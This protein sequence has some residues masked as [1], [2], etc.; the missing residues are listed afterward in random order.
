MESIKFYKLISP[1]AE[2]ITMDC[3]LSMS[4]IDDN[5]LAFKDNDIS[6]ATFDC[7]DFFIDIIRNN[8]ESINIDLSCVRD[9][10][11]QEIDEA[12]SGITPQIIEINL[13]GEVSEDGVLTLNW[14][15]MSGEQST[16]IS[17]FITEVRRDSTLKGDGTK[18]D[19]LGIANVEQT[20]YYKP[21]IDFVDELPEP[22]TLDGL[23]E[24]I[25][26]YTSTTVIA[27]ND[28]DIV[29]QGAPYTGGE[30]SAVRDGVLNF[31]A[32]RAYAQE[33]STHI[34]VYGT[35]S[36]EGNSYLKFTIN[37]DYLI[38]KIEIE[39]TGE[40]YIKTWRDQNGNPLIIFDKT[41]TWIGNEQ[42]VTLTNQES[43][44]AR[45]KTIKVTYI[46]EV[47]P[48][49]ETNS[50]ERWLTKN[51]FSTFGCLYTRNGLDV[52]KSELEKNGSVWRIPTKED[53]D[54]LL[55]FVDDCDVA[56]SGETIGEYQ[57]EVCGKMLKSKNYWIGN[58]NI[59]LIGFSALPSGYVLNSILTGKDEEC[60]FWTDT[61]HENDHKYIK[62]F[63]YNS[64]AAL[65]DT[66]EEGG[67]YSIRLVRDISD[68]Y[69]SDSVN[70]LGNT[71]KVINIPDIGQSWIKY[72]LNF[73]SGNENC[74]KFDYEYEG[75]LMDR[76]LINHWNGQNWDK[77]ELN[78][79]DKINTTSGRTVTEYTCVEDEHGN[80]HLVKGI[81]YEINNGIKSMIIDAGWY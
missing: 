57:G 14:T 75:T 78:I 32:N 58:T 62:G 71:Y 28:S 79:G 43:G 16:S 77:K 76:Y 22:G 66:E 11:Q 65:Q 68:N 49:S 53:W 34:K 61:E 35:N 56:I 27:Y 21:V 3:K 70:I 51:T 39:A 37:D 42:I 1:Y 13:S 54:A 6:A 23:G 36:S 29:G 69:V 73:N 18:I 12:I 59:D 24:N 60:R 7:E 52:V 26:V 80:Q 48:S 38:T 50:G 64:D 17:G 46:K 15:D 8:G 10:I 33:N 63:S 2:D 44:Q 4:D 25:Q 40:S 31:Y 9:E 55:T 45:V 72:N 20:G 19:P 67:W 5:F 81:K 74:G 47:V 41:A 30:I